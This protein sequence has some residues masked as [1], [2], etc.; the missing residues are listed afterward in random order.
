M[1]VCVY[2]VQRTNSKQSNG[3]LRV[4]C[5]GYSTL[6]C[7]LGVCHSLLQLFQP[8]LRGGTGSGIAQLSLD[9]YQVII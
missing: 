5:G 9:L 6:M 4:I 7:Y 8:V 3:S 2:S 1:F